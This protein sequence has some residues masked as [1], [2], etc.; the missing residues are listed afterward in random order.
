MSWLPL[1]RKTAHGFSCYAPSN[2]PM[3]FYFLYEH[4]F[5]HVIFFVF[6]IIVQSVSPLLVCAFWHEKLDPVMNGQFV[7]TLILPLALAHNSGSVVVKGTAI[8]LPPRTNVSG[9]V[10]LLPE[11]LPQE[12]QHPGEWSVGSEVI[13]WDPVHKGFK[14]RVIEIPQQA[15]PAHIHVDKTV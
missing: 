15:N 4:S 6:R 14:G 7:S 5:Q 10:W 13:E 12:S 9:H 8:T 3:L 1:Q 2:A 11:A